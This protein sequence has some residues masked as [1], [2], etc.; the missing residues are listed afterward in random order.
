M[1]EIADAGYARS[2]R[3][4]MIPDTPLPITPRAMMSGW[5]C[6]AYFAMPTRYDC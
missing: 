1:I 2:R 4:A 5:L 6:A 3:Y